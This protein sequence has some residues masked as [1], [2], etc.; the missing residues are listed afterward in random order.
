MTRGEAM[1]AAR[2]KRG[3]SIRDLSERS[4]YSAD[5]ICQLERNKRAGNIDTIT[6][7]ADTLG[8]SIDEYVG[9]EQK[10]G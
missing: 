10:G 8:V 3:L 6:D 5:T 4:G 2:K 9:H 7:L 1:R